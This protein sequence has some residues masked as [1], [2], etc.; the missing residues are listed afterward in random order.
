MTGSAGSS[1]GVVRESGQ[2]SGG[3]PVASGVPGL[4]LVFGSA[5][6]DSVDILAG[7]PGFSS[8]GAAS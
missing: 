6:V 2:V 8:G 4:E 3:V 7:E 1:L 5:S